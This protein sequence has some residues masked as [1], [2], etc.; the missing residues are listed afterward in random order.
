VAWSED[1]FGAGTLILKGDRLLILTENGELVLAPASPSGFRPLARARVLDGTA[2]AY[3]A[4]SAG[5]LY[6]RNESTL[7]CLE[8]R[9]TQGA[10]SGK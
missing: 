8:L 1:R 6:A 5:R 7:V 3:P 10:A 4:L 9:K 2:R